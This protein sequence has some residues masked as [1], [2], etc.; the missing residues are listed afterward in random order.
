VAGRGQAVLAPA[1]IAQL[2]SRTITD[3]EHA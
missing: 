3:G 1:H 2:A